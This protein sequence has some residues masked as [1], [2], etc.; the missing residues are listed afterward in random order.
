MNEKQAKAGGKPPA[1]GTAGRAQIIGWSFGP[2]GE[3]IYSTIPTLFL[4]IINVFA[5]VPVAEERT[6]HVFD[7]LHFVGFFKVALHA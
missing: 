6:Q 4:R 7:V 5:P 2:R 3:A 1:Y